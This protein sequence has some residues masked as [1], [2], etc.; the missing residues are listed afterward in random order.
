[1]S[2]AL[3]TPSPER[4]IKANMT[5]FLR[6]VEER[7]GPPDGA[8]ISPARRAMLPRLLPRCFYDL[9]IEVAIVR[10]GPIQGGMVHP[11]LRRRSGQ[12]PVTYPS[13]EVEQG[14][15][16]HAGVPG[17]PSRR[18]RRHRRKTRHEFF[19]IG[20]D[21]RDRR[22]QRRPPAG[23]GRRPAE[24][25]RRCP[26]RDPRSGAAP[27]A[28]VRPDRA[29]RNVSGRGARS[30]SGR[31]RAAQKTDGA[32]ALGSLEAA[33]AG[34]AHTPSPKAAPM[35]A[36][37]DTVRPNAI[38]PI[39]HPP[40]ATSRHARS[41]ASLRASGPEASSAISATKS[42]NADWAASGPSTALIARRTRLRRSST[43]SIMASKYGTIAPLMRVSRASPSGVMW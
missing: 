15:R 16:H 38:A 23:R 31:G 22:L 12:E 7:G 28:V 41:R 29:R 2:E 11:Y 40:G 42:D 24:G 3:W 9:V 37:G 30:R 10:P 19:V 17:L 18:Q 20:Y 5:E 4:I 26:L 25:S 43:A 13:P 27:A 1:M 32:A 21:R 6:Y 35:G 14:K 39:A 8:L 36:M 34:P 33:K